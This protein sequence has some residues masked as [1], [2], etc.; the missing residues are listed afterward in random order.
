MSQA[1]LNKD[2][3]AQPLDSATFVQKFLARGERWSCLVTYD[4]EG[5]RALVTNQ[6]MAQLVYGWQ[7]A[8]RRWGCGPGDSVWALGA[9]SSAHA[10]SFF[11]AASALGGKVL[12]C[13]RPPSE[14]D[15]ELWLAQQGCHSAWIWPA[16]AP[17]LPLLRQKVKGRTLA[18]DQEDEPCVQV[19]E[20][21]GERFYRFQRLSVSS[22]MLL[23]PPTLYTQRLWASAEALGRALQPGESLLAVGALD[24]PDIF[25]FLLAAWS[26]R[27]MC[28][29]T[30]PAEPETV[31][32]RL[33]TE[34]SGVVVLRMRDLE[35]L[36]EGVETADSK[37]PKW[38]AHVKQFLVRGL[39]A[40]LEQLETIGRK[41][42]YRPLYGWRVE[43]DLGY[44]ALIPPD[45]GDGAE[46]E[47]KRVK[48][49]PVGVPLSHVRVEEAADGRLQVAFAGEQP[50]V[51]T[52][53]FVVS[54]CQGKRLVVLPPSPPS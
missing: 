3:R 7:E 26:R 53:G 11:L 15:I 4:R 32:L 41:L 18:V 14:S 30:P 16:A 49:T 54:L 1:Q 45:L 13:R 34:R 37:L 35:E 21:K 50:A 22:P 27:A 48:G 47:L 25:L 33:S 46:Q 40:P 10:A 5:R 42:R 8:L 38:R 6:E 24:E 9:P 29:L 28:A 51:E 44:V 39:P 36:S 23:L 43:G 12:Y 31:W 17:L 52:E 19:A 2:V 20:L